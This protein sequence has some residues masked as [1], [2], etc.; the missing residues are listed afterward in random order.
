MAPDSPQTSA[1]GISSQI[2][3]CYDAEKSCIRLL[4]GESVL[5]GSIIEM[6][7]S[8]QFAGT[9]LVGE[10]VEI[11]IMGDNMVPMAVHNEKVKRIQPAAADVARNHDGGSL[12]ENRSLNSHPK[13]YVYDELRRAEI[14]SLMKDK[15][16][17]REEKLRRLAEIRAKYEDQHSLAASSSRELSQ[18]SSHVNSL[19]RTA[20]ANNNIATNTVAP[21]MATQKSDTNTQII[22]MQQPISSEPTDPQT[23]IVP[24]SSSPVNRWNRAAVAAVTMNAVSK[25]MTHPKSD[26][27]KQTLQQVESLPPK[28]SATAADSSVSKIT[29]HQPTSP[30][31]NKCQETSAE[32]SPPPTPKTDDRRVQATNAAARSSITKTQPGTSDAANRWNRAAVA[33]VT[34]NTFTQSFTTAQTNVNQEDVDDIIEHLR[35]NNPA[36]K[37]LI[38]D[39]RRFDDASWEKLFDSIEENEHLSMLSVVDCGLNDYTVSALVLALVENETLI[40]I[41]LSQNEELTDETSLGML[42]VIKQGNAFVKR[43]NIEGT[44][45]S[46]E[47]AEKIQDI[48]CERDDSLKLAKIQKEREAKIKA[49]LSVTASDQVRHNRQP[50]RRLSSRDDSD[51]D[52]EDDGGARIPTTAKKGSQRSFYSTESKKSG[53][54]SESGDSGLSRRRVTTVPKGNPSNKLKAAVRANMATR[55]MANLGGDMAHV[56]KSVSQQIELRKQRGECVHC[57][58]KC[59]TKTMFKTIPLTIPNKVQEGRCLRCAQ[60]HR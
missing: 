49:L 10:V 32:D 53:Q 33:A 59:F 5:E 1:S 40:S 45:I 60:L 30:T 27:Q 21:S 2:S 50:T 8:Q 43:I 35:L 37:T 52:E 39:R 20:V 55:Q 7:Q 11:V 22:A 38:L 48:L 3:A 47:V 54:S 16:I 12:V 24:E 6:E 44:S 56:G 51:D 41:D 17:G 34:T 57:G 36:L 4:G 42:K 18:S 14:Q 15:T 9:F 23:V 29:I 19:N 26:T 46:P 28:S 25:S 31:E 58:Q 13:K